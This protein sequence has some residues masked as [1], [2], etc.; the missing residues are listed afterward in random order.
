MQ[1]IWYWLGIT[2]FVVAPPW[3]CY[4]LY[5]DVTHPETWGDWQKNPYVYLP[6]LAV[7]VI[8]AALL[9]GHILLTEVRER[10]ERRSNHP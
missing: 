5:R 7:V 4:V 9:G 2:F 6:M 10:R 8:V 3:F 1:R